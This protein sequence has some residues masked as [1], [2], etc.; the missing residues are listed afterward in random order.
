MA[1]ELCGGQVIIIRLRERKD[2]F[3]SFHARQ[4]MIDISN[5]I[6]HHLHVEVTSFK[7]FPYRRFYR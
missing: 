2:K 6:R 3:F 5:N 4:R 1:E 7:I